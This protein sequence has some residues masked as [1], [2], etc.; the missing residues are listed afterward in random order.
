MA[1]GVGALLGNIIGGRLGDTRPFTTTFTTAGVTVLASAGILLF[2]RH[3]IPLVA[4]FTL[5]GLVG[6]SANPIL[7]SLAVRYGGAAPTL[8]TAMPTSIFNLG[9]A[10]GT[11]IS[12]IA[13]ESSLGAIGP[14]V[15]GT[16][17]AVLILAPLGLLA[18]LESPR[19]QV[20]L[21][22]R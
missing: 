13:L 22:Q 8:A 3:P 7:V 9:T 5:L 15:V 4:L 17:G 12:G 11:G 14:T 6:L 21:E 2:S 20:A 10:I 19:H 1:F 16:I 18:F